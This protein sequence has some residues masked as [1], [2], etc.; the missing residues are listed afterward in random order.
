[1]SDGPKW[2]A[3]QQKVIDVRNRNILVS[4]AAGSGKT[5]V[6]V[7]RIITMISDEKNPVD[8]DKLLVVTFTNAAA[9]EMSE[10]IATALEKKV[11]KDPDNMFLRRQ[12]NLVRNA[13]ICTFHSFCQS[14]IRNHFNEIGLDPSFRIGDE[15]ELKLLQNDVMNDMFEEHYE[16]Y[17]LKKEEA[18]K[19]GEKLSANDMAFTDLIESY[20]DGRSDQKVRE[21][22]LSLYRFSVSCPRP[23]KWLE[24]NKKAFQVETLEDMEQQPWLQMLVEHLQMLCGGI[25]GKYPELIRMC[26]GVGGPIFYEEALQDDLLFFDEVAHCKSY[27]AMYD[28]ISNHKWKTFSRKKCDT[29]DAEVKE[30][31]KAGRDAF[32]KEMKEKVVE[33]FFFQTP[34][35]MRQDICALKHPM[36]M[37]IDLAK[38]FRIRYQELKEEKRVVDFNDLEHYALQI[39][40]DENDEPS[41]VAMAYQKE[42]AEILVDEY[43]DSNDVQETILRSIAKREPQAPNVFMVGDVKQSIYK[44]RMAKPE[45]FMEKYDT[46]TLEDSLYQRIDLHKHFRSRGIV[47]DSVNEIFQAIMKKSM[48]KVEY[49]E[50]VYLNLGNLS[51]PEGERSAKHAELLLYTGETLAVSDAT[52]ED[53]DEDTSGS[54]GMPSDEELSNVEIEA[55]MVLKRIKELTNP[56]TGLMVADKKTNELRTCG[57]GDIAILLRTM[58]GWSDTYLEVLKNAGVPVYTD[59]RTGYFVAYEVRTILEFLKVLDNPRQ[60]I[61]LAAVLRSV[62]GEFSGEELARMRSRYSNMPLIDTVECFAAIHELAGE[63]VTVFKHAT[64]KNVSTDDLATGEHG[65]SHKMESG[66]ETISGNTELSRSI[67]KEDI[68]LSKKADL[69]LKRVEEFRKRVPYTS[70]HQLLEE[71]YEETGFYD[72]VSVMPNGGQRRDNL[73]MLVQKALALEATN[74]S[75]LFHFNRYIEKLHKYEVDFGEALGAES[76]DQAVRIMSI[77]KSKGLEFPVVIVGG[78]AK[79]FNQQDTKSKVVMHLDAG[80]GADVIDLNLRT[81]QKSLLKRAIGQISILENLGEEQ[82]VLYVAL[83]RAREKLIMA[84]MAPKPEDMEQWHLA[85][86][87]MDYFTKTKAKNYLDWVGP[88]IASSDSG[89]FVVKTYGTE[90]LIVEEM[91]EQLKS[92][93]KELQF[94]QWDLETEYDKEMREMLQKQQ[95]FSYAFEHEKSIKS[96]M[97]VSELKHIA[98]EKL[99]AEDDEELSVRLMD[100][101]KVKEKTS[102]TLKKEAENVKISECE[103]DTLIYEEIPLPD[104]L[105]EKE[106]IRGAHRGT[107]YHTVFDKLN[108]QQILSDEDISQELDRMVANYYLTTEEAKVVYRR[109]ILAFAQSDVGQRI[110]KAD[111][112]NRVWREQ[113]FVIGIP[114]REVKTEWDSDERILVQGIIDVYFEE[115]DGIVLLDYK[116][117]KAKDGKHLADMYREQLKY[118]AMA[119]EQM[120]GKKVKEQI[121]FWATKGEEIKL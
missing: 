52:E 92:A 106:E 5:A 117:D 87:E 93:A 121:L 46:Y 14:V 36:C 15:T 11:E 77:H 59:T 24:K 21:L 6:L 55:R 17:G 53:F 29:E 100:E 72:Y 58:S 88:V 90:D 33:K 4:A 9:A 111:A 25:A 118:Y 120:T 41:K 108:L 86:G 50:S 109:D 12:V 47:L 79:Q 96:K 1:M 80:I 71:I 104:F 95:E 39:L 68:E 65:T 32:K 37:L 56:D 19:N 74:K 97:S 44:F 112:K 60:D 26:T 99:L 18:A 10:R 30:K 70:I 16:A 82:R 94:R 73:D 101:V 75:T 83:T 63:A 91:K 28:V 49:D 20:A 89:R 119:I 113:P 69:F 102:G 110:K 78:M 103:K 40:L 115:E 43:Q 45:L 62:L 51:F 27:S 7:E 3:E 48:G 98:M 22:V 54:H 61:P 105:K 84:G 107:V 66:K 64:E 2:T 31:V 57:Y 76:T 13:H 23:E 67:T 114:A 35:E 116:T 38:E 34:E 8:I 42:F 81:K 85:D